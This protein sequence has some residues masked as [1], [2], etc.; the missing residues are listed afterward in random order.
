MPSKT[1][2]LA[3]IMKGKLGF[4]RIF[5][6]TLSFNAPFFSLG[7]VIW[8]GEFYFISFLKIELFKI[9]SFRILHNFNKN[10]NLFYNKLYK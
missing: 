4:G 10:N 5:H 7:H 6:V 1:W 3:W 9:M 2:I 8:K